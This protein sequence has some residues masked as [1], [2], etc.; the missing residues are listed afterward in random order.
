LDR[1]GDALGWLLTVAVLVSV[2]V[3]CVCGCVRRRGSHATH[4][5]EAI[6][7]EITE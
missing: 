6:Y 5:E 3:P 4:Y 1:F 7:D 2:V